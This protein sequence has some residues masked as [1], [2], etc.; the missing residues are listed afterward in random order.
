M[1][2][3]KRC[4]WCNTKNPLYVSYHDKEWCVPRFDDA[5]LFEMLLLESFQ[6]GLSW[7]CV[8]NKREAFRVA[9]DGFD[10]RLISEYGEEKLAALAE[11]KSI[12]RNKLKIRAAKTNACVFL[13]IACEYGSFS[14]YLNNF[15]EGKIIYEADKT[16]SDLSDA[17]SADL[18]GRGMKFVGSTVIYSYLQAI[19]AIYSHSKECFLYKDLNF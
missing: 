18:V 2:E 10:A 12:I 13:S 7:E 3:L 4:K 11:N 5:Y 6:A 15:T 8:L 1:S 19:G 17:L 14:N 9:F 16:V